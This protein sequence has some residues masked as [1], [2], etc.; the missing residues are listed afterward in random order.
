MNERLIRLPE[1]VKM[2]G[3]SKTTIWR[4]EKKG[5]FPKHFNITVRTSAWK[6]SDIMAYIQKV[7]ST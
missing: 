5:E 2:T 3:L 4:Y 7:T 1:V 6:L